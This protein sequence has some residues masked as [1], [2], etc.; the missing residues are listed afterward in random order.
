MPFM[1]HY[2]KSIILFLF[3]FMVSL[4]NANFYL[5]L[6]SNNIICEVFTCVKLEKVLDL[7]DILFKQV[8]YKTD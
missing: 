8:K 3:K 2:K 6:L 4:L 5:L 1:N 7:N